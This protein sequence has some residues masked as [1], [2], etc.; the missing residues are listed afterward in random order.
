MSNS[1]PLTGTPTD[2]LAGTLHRTEIQQGAL[3]R[4][5]PGAGGAGAHR[6]P[7]MRRVRDGTPTR[8]RRSATSSP[9]PSKWN[10]ATVP[11][12]C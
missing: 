8:A 10:F 5:Q 4:D 12:F 11:R 3:V 7:A 6:D 2:Q 9:V 1:A